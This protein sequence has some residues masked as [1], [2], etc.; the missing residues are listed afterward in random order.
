MSALHIYAPPVDK[1]IVWRRKCPLCHR[2]TTR[3]S[4]LYEYQ[5]WYHSCT[6]CGGQW[7]N[8][9]V[10]ERAHRGRGIPPAVAKIKARIK[11]YR[12]SRARGGHE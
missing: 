5:G 7:V 9:E 4:E 11:A 10:I 1:W 3:L 12:A 6:G 8:D 2:R